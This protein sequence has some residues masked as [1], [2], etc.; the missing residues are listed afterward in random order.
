VSVSEQGESS[1]EALRGEEEERS[2]ESFEAI[3]LRLDGSALET[4]LSQIGE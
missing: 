3:I 4:L 1:G 2:E